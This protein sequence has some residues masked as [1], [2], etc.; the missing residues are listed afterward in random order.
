MVLKAP[1]NLFNQPPMEVAVKK[2]DSVLATVQVSAGTDFS[3]RATAFILHYLS[4]QKEHRA[5]GEDITD[6]CKAEGI[7]PPKD[8]RSFGAPIMALSK[9]GLIVK[10]GYCKRRRG[11]A[12]NGG[13]IWKLNET[14]LHLHRNDVLR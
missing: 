4:Q 3:R 11:H 12:C 6:A 2:R 9:A 13:V 14:K 1:Y 7:K 5:P 10:D 8:D